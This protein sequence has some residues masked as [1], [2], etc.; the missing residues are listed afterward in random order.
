M[1]N[2]TSDSCNGLC[3]IP[4]PASFVF[5]EPNKL[6][7]IYTAANIIRAISTVCTVF[8]SACYLILPSRRKH[9][10]FIVLL[11]SM[12]LT[13]WEG[14]AT[15]WLFKKEEVLCKSLYEIATMDNSWLCGLQGAGLMYMTL[16]LNL[17]GFIL[18]LNLHVL[19]VY[20]STLIAD[21]MTKFIVSSFILP[22][23]FLVPAVVTHQIEYP[24]FGSIC[25]LSPSA[26]AKYFVYPLSLIISLEFLLHL[27]TLAFNFRTSIRARYGSSATTYDTDNSAQSDMSKKGHRMH[28]ARDISLLLKQQWRPSIFIYCVLFS[29][30]TFWLF[31]LIEA[32]KLANI[33]P[34]TTWFS[35]WIKCLG[36]QAMISIQSG[37]L[38]VTSTPDQLKEAGDIAQRVCAAVA[39]PY[40]PSFA[41]AAMAE[42]LPGALG[43][44]ML[45][46]FGSKM[47]LWQD[48][49]RRLSGHKEET[50]FV[51]GDIAKDFKDRQQQRGDDEEQGKLRQ[52]QQQQHQHQ[53]RR[54]KQ[55]DRIYSEELTHLPQAAARFGT[56]AQYGRDPRTAPKAPL[57]FSMPSSPLSLGSFNSGAV[58]GGPVQKTSVTIQDSRE[59]IYYQGARQASP[60]T[61]KSHQD[62]QNYHRERP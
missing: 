32:K 45:L 11:I 34:T 28:I 35:N 23:P 24:G 60:V 25:F 13:P 5:Y 46:I 53:H 54:G 49:R 48:I 15:A 30:I 38:S 16:S 27:V 3:C 17:L 4:C 41:W 47:E 50:V 37:K 33:G 14:L 55:D 2:L 56:N 62:D 40:I 12:Q 31:G 18:I 8:L 36:E 21:H 29:L 9:P 61:Y 58:Y 44:A 19:T 59:L 10:H 6:S 1:L 20:R 43:V 7:N 52:Q 22:I 39:R 42:I 57:S 51:M 26:E